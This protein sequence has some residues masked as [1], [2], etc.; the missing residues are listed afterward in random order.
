[1]Q[2]GGPVRTFTVRGASTRVVVVWWIETG[3]DVVLNHRP[4]QKAVHLDLALHQLT[5]R[6]ANHR[7]V[8]LELASGQGQLRGGSVCSAVE[9][10]AA[11][12]CT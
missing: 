7:M 11:G 9:E 5:T 2:V 4:E 8:E 3:R 1:M 6:K 10:V 12:I